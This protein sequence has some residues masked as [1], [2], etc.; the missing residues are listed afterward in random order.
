M[1]LQSDCKRMFDVRPIVMKPSIIMFAIVCLPLLGCEFFPESSF[2]LARESR[3]P[4]WFTLPPGLS[5]SDVTVT[6]NYYVNS[7]GRTS[8]FILRDAKKQKLAEVK[9]SQKG[10]E[11]LKLNDPGSGFP[12]GYPSYE[13]VTVNGVTEVIEHQKIEP[14]FYVTDDLAVWAELNNPRRTSQ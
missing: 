13:V 8:T 2:E 14:I 7:S 3:L 10:I 12:P 6:M 4:K 1:H 9:G 11:P 5:R